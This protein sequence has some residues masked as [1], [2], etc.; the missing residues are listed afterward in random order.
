MKKKLYAFIL[1]IQEY[2]ATHSLQQ[3]TTHIHNRQSNTSINQSMHREHSIYWNTKHYNAIY[4]Q[5]KLTKSVLKKITLHYY[6]YIISQEREQWFSL[7]YRT[8]VCI[9]RNLSFLSANLPSAKLALPFNR[10]LPERCS[11]QRED[12]EEGIWGRQDFTR[13]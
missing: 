12:S 6:Y 1:A 5:T 11:L 2:L 10:L 4:I 9:V 3:R 8:T 7:R 13:E